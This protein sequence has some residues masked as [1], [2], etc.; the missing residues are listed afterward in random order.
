MPSPKYHAQKD[1]EMLAEHLEFLS[2]WLVDILEYFS[3]DPDSIEDLPTISR[4]L[5]DSARAIMRVYNR[6][7]EGGGEN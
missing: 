3:E 6:L 7:T 2:N 4:A 5:L 1:L